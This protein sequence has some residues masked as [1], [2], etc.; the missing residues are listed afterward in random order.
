[1]IVAQTHIE[2]CDP[3]QQAQNN[4]FVKEWVLRAS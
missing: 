2:H 3:N 4:R 1:M